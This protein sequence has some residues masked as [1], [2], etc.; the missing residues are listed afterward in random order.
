VDALRPEKLADKPHL[1]SVRLPDWLFFTM[2]VVHFVTPRYKD[3]DVLATRLIGRD[4]GDHRDDPAKQGGASG[5][6]VQFRWEMETDGGRED[7]MPSKQQ[8]SS[9][10]ESSQELDKELQAIHWG[11]SVGITG[12]FIALMLGLTCWRFATKDY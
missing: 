8:P 12:L 9:P 11:Q 2:D 3:L 6:K 7:V 4:L 10:S 1:Q 5:F